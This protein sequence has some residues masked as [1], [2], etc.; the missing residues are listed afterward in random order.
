M[1][2]AE[3]MN[4]Q[5]RKETREAVLDIMPVLKEMSDFVT[6]PGFQFER[7]DAELKMVSDN[8][9]E[10][11]RVRLPDGKGIEYIM[12]DDPHIW[13]FSDEDN[14]CESLIEQRCIVLKVQWLL[15]CYADSFKREFANWLEEQQAKKDE[16][17]SFYY[18]EEGQEG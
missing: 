2:S 6:V 16:T 13:F 11:L 1:K 3:E 17:D 8:Y 15:A 7:D 4:E 5:F 12:D 18:L 14:G 10:Y 9:D